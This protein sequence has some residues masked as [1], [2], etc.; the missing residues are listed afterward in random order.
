M[1]YINK[2]NNEEKMSKLR[3]NLK[4]I[5]ANSKAHNITK[6]DQLQGGIMN[7]IIGKVPA[8][9]KRE[10]ITIDDLGRWIVCLLLNR[11][12][13]VLII[14]IYRILQRNDYRI[15]TSLLQYNQR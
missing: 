8:M 5:V 1:N 3:Q 11:K 9:L 15:H 7:L 14:T 10:E 13:K 4:I 12:K 2:N 6:K